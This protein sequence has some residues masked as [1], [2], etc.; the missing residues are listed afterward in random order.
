M[1]KT[2]DNYYNTNNK[3]SKN[4]SYPRKNENRELDVELKLFA[5]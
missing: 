2:E 5:R 1:T 3:Y 4:K